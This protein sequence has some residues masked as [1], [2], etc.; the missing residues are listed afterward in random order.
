VKN[1]I[2]TTKS[3]T[4]TNREI[5]LLTTEVAIILIFLYIRSITKNRYTKHGQLIINNPV[6]LD[7]YTRVKLD[8]SS[9]YNY[10]LSFWIFIHPMN[11]GSAPQATDYTTVLTCTDKPIITYNS[12]LNTMRIEMKT[13]SRQRKIVDEIKSF[14]LQKWNHIVMNYVNGTCDVFL[15]GELHNS[16]I[17]I[18][19]IKES[20]EVEIG[21]EDG[22]QGKMCNVIFFNKH[23]S[24]S[25]IKELY[26]EFSE[27]NP[28]TI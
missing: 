2:S 26:L 21:S 16:K 6:N 28:P 11:P 19:P 1:L 8:N 9:S 3:S 7:D 25:K 15:N 14:P 17:E 5:I 23:L 18:I 20:N 12:L 4:I 24:S 10:G 22:I 13:D 27:K